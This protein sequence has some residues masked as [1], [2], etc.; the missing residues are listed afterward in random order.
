M[1][2]QDL[3]PSCP[4]TW[5]GFGL[6]AK[7]RLAAFLPTSGSAP[8][9]ACPFSILQLLPSSLPPSRCQKSPE[10]ARLSSKHRVAPGGQP[11]PS[12][13]CPLLGQK[14]DVQ[15]DSPATGVISPQPLPAPG[16]TWKEMAS[17]SHRGGGGGG[18]AQLLFLRQ[19]TRMLCTTRGI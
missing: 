17:I 13:L 3:G 8:G 16:A 11:E 14:L 1:R 10:V 9:P 5:R 6:G 7:S 4:A 15:G 2:G 19:A 12:L 18:E